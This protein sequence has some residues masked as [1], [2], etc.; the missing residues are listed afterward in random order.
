MT[1]TRTDSL[2]QPSRSNVRSL[3]RI[4]TLMTSIVLLL[5]IPPLLNAQVCQTW[6]ENGGNSISAQITDN[7]TGAVI[8]D[9]AMVPAYTQVRVDSRATVSAVCHTSCEDLIADVNHT[10]VWADISTTGSW[11]GT[12]GIGY[13]FGRNPNGSA[14]YW[15]DLDT[16]NSNSTGP[17]YFTLAYPG[18]YQFH[19]QAII[20]RH[21]NCSDISDHTDT[22][23]ITINVGD[24]DGATNLGTNSCNGKVAKPVDLGKPIN[25][26]NGNMYIQQTDYRLPGI[27]DGLEITRT[28]NSK[29]QLAGVFGFGWWSI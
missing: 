26:T 29:K 11:N 10:Y 17:N 14:A 13:V 6:S 5:S 4:V 20:D 9:G 27:G 2:H 28:Y 12:Y 7:A 18:T 25:V 21:P 1:H 19:I 16:H 8:A 24:S 22:I 3:S 23:N 15:Q